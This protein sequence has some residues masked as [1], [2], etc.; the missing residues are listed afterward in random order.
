MFLPDDGIEY[1][2]AFHSLI[3]DRN[4]GAMGGGGRIWYASIS[5]YLNDRGVTDL[6]ER[7]VWERMICALDDEYMRFHQPKKEG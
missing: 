5:R 7:E 1:W 6:N 4:V 3:N 2:Q